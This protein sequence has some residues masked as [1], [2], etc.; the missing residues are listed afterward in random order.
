MFTCLVNLS[1]GHSVRYYNGLPLFRRG[2]VLRCH[3]ST[4]GFGF[5]AE[6]VTRLLDEGRSCVEMCVEAR[7]RSHGASSALTWRNFVAVGRTLL[8]IAARRYATRVFFAGSR[9]RNSRRSTPSSTRMG[10]YTSR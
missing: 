9:F 10:R 8:S 3:S 7:D 4:T 1:S 6:L 5:Q 2:D